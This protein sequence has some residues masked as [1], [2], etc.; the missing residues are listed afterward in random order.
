[1]RG[2]TKADLPGVP[3]QAQPARCAAGG[4]DVARGVLF[5]AREETPTTGATLTIDGG[6]PEAFP[7]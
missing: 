6:L 3:P 2:M 1:M 4:A 7:R 5:F